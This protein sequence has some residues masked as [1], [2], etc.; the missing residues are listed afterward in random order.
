[1]AFGQPAGPPATSRQLQELQT[2]LAEAGH[3]DFRE[4]RGPMGFSQRQAAGRFTRAEADAFIERLQAV[5][6]GGADPVAPPAWRQSAQ[7]Q[8]LARLPAE[9]LAAE[10]QRR[11][12]MVI[13]PLTP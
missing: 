7:D 11:G 10:L 4:A 1:M 9:Q 5:S 13:E 8:L 12:W 6:E 2:L 3:A